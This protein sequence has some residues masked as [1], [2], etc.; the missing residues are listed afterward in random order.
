MLFR[1]HDLLVVWVVFPFLMTRIVLLFC[2][3][4]LVVLSLLYCSHVRTTNGMH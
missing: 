1:C 4:N 2:N 3:M